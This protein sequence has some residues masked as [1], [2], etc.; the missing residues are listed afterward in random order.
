MRK[1][2]ELVPAY[3]FSPFDEGMVKIETAAKAMT[4]LCNL[5]ANAPADTQLDTGQALALLEPIERGM[6]EG[7]VLLRTIEV[8]KEAF[9]EA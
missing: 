4:A 6:K 8:I 5:I 1:S 2:K 7:A 3:D 9:V